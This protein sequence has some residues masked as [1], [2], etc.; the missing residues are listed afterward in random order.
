MARKKSKNTSRPIVR[1]FNEYFGAGTLADWQRLCQDVGLDGDY[2]SIT[3]C[4]KVDP[5]P[6]SQVEDDTG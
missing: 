1:E 5:R 2:R 3:Q 6:E 4:R